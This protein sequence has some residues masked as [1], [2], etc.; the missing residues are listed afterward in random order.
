MGK[1]L[2][3]TGQKFNR[4][5]A[6]R[7]TGEKQNDGKCIWLFKCDCGNEVKIAASRVKRGVI[8]S[9]GCL[10]NEISSK[11]MIDMHTTHG[12]WHNKMYNRAKGILERCNNPNNNSYKNYGG[13]GIKC[14]LGENIEDVICNL[15]SIDGYFEG[16]QIDRINNDGHYEIGNLRWATAS[17]NTHNI[18][19]L[20]SNNT[21]GVKGVYKCRN[22]YFAE[23]TIKG[24]VHREYFP[25]FEEAVW[26]RQ[27]LEEYYLL[28]QFINRG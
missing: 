17:E 7:D 25:T 24:V 27:S 13:R 1:K 22:K 3:L 21:S 4:L 19:K 18:R 11:R 5:M 6:I 16:A 9:C 10:A 20:K 23:I 28:K 2:D 15:E 14:L 8:K 26:Y 12:L